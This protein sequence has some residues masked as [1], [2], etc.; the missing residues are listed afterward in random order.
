MSETVIVEKQPIPREHRDALLEALMAEANHSDDV[1]FSYS[2]RPDAVHVLHTVENA[3][4][5]KTTRYV[6]PYQ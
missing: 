6:Y 2:D 3:Q 1:W 5:S 4:G